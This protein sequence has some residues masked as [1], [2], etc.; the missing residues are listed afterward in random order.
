LQTSGDE[1][2]LGV[3]AGHIDPWQK[4]NCIPSDILTALRFDL[5]PFGA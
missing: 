4:N 5:R 2:V 3:E 1:G